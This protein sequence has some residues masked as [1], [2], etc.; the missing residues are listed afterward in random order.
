MN[1]F[2]PFLICLVFSIKHF[3][4]DFPLQ[5]EGMLKKF[6]LDPKEWIPALFMHSYVHFL[7]T[8]LVLFLFE[9]LF[10]TK[11]SVGTTLTFLFLVPTFNSVIHF[12]MDRIKASPNM[13]GQYKALSGK[14][15][16]YATQTEKK[17]NWLF[18]QCLGIDQWVHSTTDILCAYALYLWIQ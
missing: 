7:G 12:I 6:S 2:T 3:I 13:L 14:E 4:C 16:V 5:T 1:S 15:F 9:V 17:S 11:H 8:F 10:Q 18:W